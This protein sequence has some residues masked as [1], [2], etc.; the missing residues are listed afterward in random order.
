M[1]ELKN[2]IDFVLFVDVQDG[3]P[4]VTPMPAIYPVWMQK[5]VKV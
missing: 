3:N 2:K 1:E 5:P 4:M